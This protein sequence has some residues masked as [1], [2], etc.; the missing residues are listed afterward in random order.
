MHNTSFSGISIRVATATLL[1]GDVPLTTD[2]AFKFSMCCSTIGFL[3]RHCSMTRNM[4]LKSILSAEFVL[5]CPFSTPADRKKHKEATQFS[6]HNHR[7][8]HVLTILNK[9]NVK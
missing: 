7:Q 5:T 4:N 6:L 1:R 3:N 8:A 2:T 9:S